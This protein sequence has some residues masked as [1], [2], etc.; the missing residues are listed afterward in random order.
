MICRELRQN[1]QFTCDL[2]LAHGGLT[3]DALE[4][5]LQPQ[6]HAIAGARAQHVFASASLDE[7]SCH[8]NIILYSSSEALQMPGGSR[9]KFVLDGST[10][11]ESFLQTTPSSSRVATRLQLTCR[12]SAASSI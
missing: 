10:V 9:V 4:S 3:Q 11:L 1:L 2:L 6:L 12:S 5:A 8:K 7:S